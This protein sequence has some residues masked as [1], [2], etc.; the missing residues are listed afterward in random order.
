M[1]HFFESFDSY[2]NI[3]PQENYVKWAKNLFTASS[4]PFEIVKYP[5]AVIP[6]L[7]LACCVIIDAV[8]NV[9]NAKMKNEIFKTRAK[10]ITDSVIQIVFL[11]FFCHFCA[12]EILCFC[13]LLNIEICNKYGKKHLKLIKISFLYQSHIKQQ[14]KRNPFCKESVGILD[15][16]CKYGY[17]ILSLGH[18]MHPGPQE[19]PRQKWPRPIYIQESLFFALRN[20][21]PLWWHRCSGV[22]S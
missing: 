9:Y 14:N 10:K 19:H 11:M 8:L 5:R 6:K 16:P 13:G 18:G 20:V 4:V 17:E 3:L 15:A 2:K 12:N 22:Q 1:L 21:D 7:A